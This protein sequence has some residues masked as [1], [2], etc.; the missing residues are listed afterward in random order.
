MS[1]SIQVNGSGQAAL[2][3]Q[4]PDR[5]AA[6]KLEAAFIAE[7]LKASGLGK[8]PE[9]FGGGA[10]E[11]QFASFLR[12]AQAKEIVRAGGFGLAAVFEAQLKGEKQ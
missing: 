4:P 12:E 7:M 9:G 11:D 5:L 8:A 3:A 6:K 2:A 1:L 10:G